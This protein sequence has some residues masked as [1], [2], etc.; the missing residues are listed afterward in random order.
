M[1]KR[2]FALF[3]LSLFYCHFASAQVIN[4]PYRTL[5]TTMQVGAIPGSTSV[6]SQI[7]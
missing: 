7:L 2:Y 1:K 4:L 5:D 3:I 6:T